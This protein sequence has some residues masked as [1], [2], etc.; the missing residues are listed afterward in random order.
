M[1][2]SCVDNFDIG[3]IRKRMNKYGFGCTDAAGN[4]DVAYLKKTHQ[5]GSYPIFLV[6]IH[7]Y[8]VDTQMSVMCKRT[9]FPRI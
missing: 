6:C 7:N 2:L 5:P 1:L 9:V 3:I 8:F 4:A